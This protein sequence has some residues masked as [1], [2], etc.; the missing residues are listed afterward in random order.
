MNTVGLDEEL[1]RRYVN[2]QEKQE[3]KRERVIR[4]ST[5]G[6][7][8]QFCDFVV[9]RASAAGQPPCFLPQLRL[10]ESGPSWPGGTGS[11][12]AQPSEQTG[13]LNNAMHHKVTDAI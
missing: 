11:E 12:R 8:Y 10:S 9:H 1:V 5:Q 2:Y 7:L 13:R 4:S 3:K 6:L